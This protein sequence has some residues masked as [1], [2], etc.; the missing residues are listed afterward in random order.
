MKISAWLPLVWMVGWTSQTEIPATCECAKPKIN[1]YTERAEFPS[2]VCS[3]FCIETIRV[4]HSKVFATEKEADEFAQKCPANVCSD[5]T[6]EQ[7][8]ED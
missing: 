2:T 8:K 6:I 1:P 7:V 3:L 5:W 4:K